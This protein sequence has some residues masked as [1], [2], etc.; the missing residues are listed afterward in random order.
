MPD[1]RQ[2]VRPQ[3]AESTANHR[4]ERDYKPMA[5]DRILW[6][7]HEVGHMTEADWRRSRAFYYGAIAMVDDIVG[8][9]LDTAREVGLYDDLHIIL[10]GDQG[11]VMALTLFDKGPYAYDELMRIPLIIRNLSSRR[12]EQTVWLMILQRWPVDAFNDGDVD[13]RSLTQLMAKGDAADA[14]R[15]D[16]A[17]LRVVQRLVVWFACT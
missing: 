8:E 4:I 1:L 9:L 3:R 17:V 7:W 6:P 2:Y 15:E 11:G 12:G 5:Q 13:G 16:T 10:V 14:G